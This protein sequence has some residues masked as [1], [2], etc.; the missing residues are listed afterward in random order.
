LHF[1]Y[2]LNDANQHLFK[3]N[4]SFELHI[5][6]AILLKPGHTKHSYIIV[7]CSNLVLTVNKSHTQIMCRAV[8]EFDL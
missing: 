4:L 2:L 1:I 3:H 7:G 5:Y 8:S 6:S